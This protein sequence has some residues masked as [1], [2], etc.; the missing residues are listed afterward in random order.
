MKKT[1]LKPQLDVENVV[2]E[3]GIANSVNTTA[4]DDW[5]WDNSNDENVLVF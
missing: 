5:T 1:Y 3:K 4:I 2:V